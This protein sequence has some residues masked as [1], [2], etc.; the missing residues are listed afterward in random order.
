VVQRFKKRFRKVAK[1]LDAAAG[2]LLAFGVPEGAQE[3]IC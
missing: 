1:L 3:Q 2:P